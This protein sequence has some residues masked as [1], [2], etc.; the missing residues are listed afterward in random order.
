MGG[1]RVSKA[2][3]VIAGEGYTQLERLT[4]ACKSA[5]GGRGFLTCTVFRCTE[6]QV[7]LVNLLDSCVR[8]IQRLL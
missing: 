8:L 2:S 1:L 6:I 7:A 5:R 3:A 4:R